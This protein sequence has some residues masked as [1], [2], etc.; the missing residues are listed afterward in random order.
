MS[1]CDPKELIKWDEPNAMMWKGTCASPESQITKFKP[2][3]FNCDSPYCINISG[4]DNNSY[5][6]MWVPQN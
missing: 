6:A 5:N 3:L 4:V 1:T 2:G